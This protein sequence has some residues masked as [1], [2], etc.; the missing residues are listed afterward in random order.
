MITDPNLVSIVELEIMISQ[1]L[2]RNI[3]AS[4]AIKLV[5]ELQIAE[6]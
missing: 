5:T 3:F 6:N 2:A 4:S 1:S